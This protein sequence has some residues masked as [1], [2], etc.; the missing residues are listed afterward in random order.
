M[1]TIYNNITP[2]D[3]STNFKKDYILHSQASSK[4]ESHVDINKPQVALNQP[5]NISQLYKQTLNSI[6]L[7]QNS[8]ITSNNTNPSS[9]SNSNANAQPTFT[10]NHTPNFN[11]NHLI[12]DK[13]HQALDYLKLATSSYKQP[14]I[15]AK[16]EQILE[17]LAKLVKNPLINDTQKNEINKILALIKKKGDISQALN[18]RLIAILNS[19]VN[20]ESVSV[21]T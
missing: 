16:Q 10:P 17:S 4:L 14:N 13:K 18:N 2:L 15:D 6:K 3:N 1:S 8:I 7:L 19:I 20:N 11:A 21:F 12:L 9:N 5:G